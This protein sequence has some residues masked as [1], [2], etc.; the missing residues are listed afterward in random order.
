[1]V[2]G[3][4][5]SSGNFEV[6][7]TC[8]TIVGSSNDSCSGAIVLKCGDNVTGDNSIRSESGGKPFPDIFYKYTG[9]RT[10]EF[11]T[12]SLSGGGTDYDSLIHIF[13]DCDLSNE[14]AI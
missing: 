1:M 6:T 4:G 13:D 12:T 5:L 8:E 9:L 2:E 11:V 3:S 14:I 7:I 10:P